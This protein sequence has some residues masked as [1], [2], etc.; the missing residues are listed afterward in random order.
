MELKRI[1]IDRLSVRLPMSIL[2]NL[3]RRENKSFEMKSA[4]IMGWRKKMQRPGCLG[5]LL[6]DV[7]APL[8]QCRQG[9]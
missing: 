6:V 9:F 4:L 3:F 7:T 8:S 1:S 2:H 5:T